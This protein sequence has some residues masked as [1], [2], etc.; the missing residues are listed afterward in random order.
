MIQPLERR[1]VPGR[2]TKGAVRRR[3]KNEEA[4]ATR[5]FLPTALL[6]ETAGR[7]VVRFPQRPHDRVTH[8]LV[9]ARAVDD[10]CRQKGHGFAHRLADEVVGMKCFTA[11]LAP[12][13]NKRCIAYWFQMTGSGPVQVLPPLVCTW[14]R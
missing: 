9:Q 5:D 13:D 3:E 12:A 2:K 4:V 8:R 10:I 6:H 7:D 11:A 14:M 1:A